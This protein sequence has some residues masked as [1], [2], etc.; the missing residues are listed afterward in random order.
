MK[1]WEKIVCLP[2]MCHKIKML[3]YFIIANTYLQQQNASF[4]KLRK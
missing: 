1:M 3:Y 4:N 2:I